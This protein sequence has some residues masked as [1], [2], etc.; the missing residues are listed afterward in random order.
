MRPVIVIIDSALKNIVLSVYDDG[1]LCTKY[2]M[3]EGS[4]LDTYSL[5]YNVCIWQRPNVCGYRPQ[6]FGGINHLCAALLK[7]EEHA[8][9]DADARTRGAG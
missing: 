7:R 4:N 6:G 1:R 9:L 5:F 8:N 2:Q 3:S